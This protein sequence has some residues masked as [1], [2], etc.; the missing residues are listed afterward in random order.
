MKK[1]IT[2]AIALTGLGISPADQSRVFDYDQLLHLDAEN[3]AEGGIKEGYAKVLPLLKK[4]VKAPASIEEISDPNTPKYS[5]ISDGIRYDIY[6]PQIP[7][8]RSWG[9]ATYALF[10]LVNRQL[11]GSAYRFYAINS[12]NDLGGMFLTESQVK[13]AT[14]TIKKKSDWPYIPTKDHPWYGQHR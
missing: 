14:I 9:N 8:E 2:F 7:A 11:T 5:V 13:A 3:L 10:N 1:F 12:G 4:Y 6:G